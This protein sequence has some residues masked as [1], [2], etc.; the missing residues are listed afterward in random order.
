MASAAACPHRRRLAV[1]VAHQSQS[2]REATQQP[3]AAAG[4]AAPF[5]IV[6]M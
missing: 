2:H 4:A 6:F 5:K 1:L 3:L